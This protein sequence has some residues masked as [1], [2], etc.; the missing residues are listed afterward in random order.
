MPDAE[1]DAN[2]LRRRVEALLEDDERRRQL[3]RRMYEL[4]TPG[5]AGEVAERLLSATEKVWRT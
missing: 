3:G 1:V 2:S 5:A 4:A